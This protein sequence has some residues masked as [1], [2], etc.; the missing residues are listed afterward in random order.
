MIG[1]VPDNSCRDRTGIDHR[2]EVSDKSNINSITC[3]GS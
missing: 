2:L 3:L 1:G